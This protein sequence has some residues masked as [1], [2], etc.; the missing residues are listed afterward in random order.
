MKLFRSGVL[1]L[2][3][4]GILSGQYLQYNHPELNW[5]TFETDHFFIHYHQDEIRSA[6]LVAKIAEDIYEP[7]VGLYQYEP[8]TKIHFIVRDHEDNANGAAYYYDNKVEIWAPPAD[9]LLRGDHAWLRNVVTHELSHMISL[10]A[11]RKF[12]RQIPAFYLQWIDYEKEKR[13]DVIHGYPNKLFSLPYAG[14]IVP[15]WFA[16]G[17]AQFQRAGFEYDTWDSHRDMLLR[18]ATLENKLLSL[19]EMG[20][21]GKNSVNNERVYNQG[22]GL[23]LFISENY[24]EEKVG[25]LV[26]AMQTPWAT[27]FN[28][29]TKKVLHITEKKLYQEWVGWLKSRYEAGTASIQEARVE[30]RV[31]ENVGIGNLYPAWSPDGSRLAWLSNRGE[32]YMGLRSLWITDSS[33]DKKKKIAE[34]VASS[35]SWSPDGNKLIYGKKKLYGNGQK[36]FELYTYDFKTRKKKRITTSKRARFPDW[37]PKGDRIVT[38]IEQDG[39]SNLALVSPNGKNWR[40]IT[41]LMNG[42]QIFN[43]HWMPDSKTILFTIFSDRG[44]RDIAKIDSSGQ[45]IEYIVQTEWDTRDAVPAPDGKSIYYSSDETGIFNIH[46]R[47]LD[48]GKDE[49]VTQVQGGAFLPSLSQSGKLAYSLFTADGYKLALLEEVESVKK[50]EYTSPYESIRKNVSKKSWPITQ[51]DDLALPEIDAKPYTTTYSKLAFLPRI[52]MDFPDKPKLGAYFYGSDVLDKYSIFGG[53]AINSQ[54]DSDLFVMFNY[55]QF[56]PTLFIELYQMRRH[57]S[58]EDYKYKYNLMGTDI[59]ADWKL[60]EGNELRTAYQFSRYDATMT[61]IAQNQEIKIPYTYH[62]GNVFQVKWNY[63]GVEPRLFSG[64]APNKGRKFELELTAHSENFIEGFEVHKDFGTLVETTVP[65]RYFRCQIDYREYLPF[66][67]P[68]TSLALR[69]RGGGIDRPV[70]SFYNFFGGG[71]DGL[72]GY[73]FYSIEGRKMAQAG[74]ALRFPIWRKAGVKVAFF[75]LDNIYGSLYG[76]I[77]NAWDENTLSGLDWKTDIGAQLR[78]GLWGFY[79]FPMRFFVDAAYGLNSFEHEEVEY[80]KEIRW[81]FGLLFDFLD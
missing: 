12:P 1:F 59:G 55:R 26:R 67:I 34:A 50:L 80:G 2:F 14:T 64:I 21:F 71:L 6:R 70:D 25:E 24:G 45:A 46:R 79:G 58:E 63:Y 27:G 10:G 74:A 49:Q 51:Y 18:T 76:D 32:D 22:Y 39:T 66:L 29:A 53:G 43:P 65:Y 77:G 60:W 35:V 17:M 28:H 16:E 47:F 48:S 41:T 73:P 75:N 9:F 15:M 13:K 11:A 8:D 40:Q 68:S 5:K 33:L 3:C 4:T 52:M 54:W 44:G 23:T 72:K 38:V 19:N 57:T 7:I 37:S 30:G 69:L 36:Y 31:I 42:E 61:L 20:I 56:L 62:T 78:F 81:Y